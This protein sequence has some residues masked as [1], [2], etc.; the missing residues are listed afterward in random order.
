MIVYLKLNIQNTPKEKSKFT[1]QPTKLIPNN[2][3]CYYH[4]EA[5]S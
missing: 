1:K 4:Q 3:V 5:R 2:G